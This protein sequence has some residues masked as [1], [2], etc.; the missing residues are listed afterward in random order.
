MLRWVGII[1]SSRGLEVEVGMATLRQRNSKQI[2]GVMMLSDNDDTRNLWFLGT[3]IHGW[4][5]ALS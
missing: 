2:S 4:S 5:R 1:D 3:S